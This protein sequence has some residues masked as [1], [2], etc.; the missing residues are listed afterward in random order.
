MTLAD[1][2]GLSGAKALARA[3]GREKLR[4]IALEPGVARAV[5]QAGHTAVVAEK[6]TLPDGEPRAD[7]LCVAGAPDDAAFLRECARALK[8]GGIV[9]LATGMASARRERPQVMALLLHAGLV[10]LAQRWSRGIVLSSG[11]VRGDMYRP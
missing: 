5:E 8:P 3:L 6:G 11:R 10:D 2:L 9:L 7:A 4:V 1:A